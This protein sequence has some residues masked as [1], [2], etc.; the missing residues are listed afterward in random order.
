M[1]L[2]KREPSPRCIDPGDWPERSARRR[3]LI[4][5]PDRSDLWAHAEILREAGY[6]V[7]T[8]TGPTIGR[9]SVSMFQR[10]SLPIEDAEPVRAEHRSLCPLVAGERCRLADGADVVISTTALVD[11]RGILAA[12]SSTGQA[13]LVVEGTKRIL[14]RNSDV[15]GAAT[16]IEQPVTQERLVAAVEEALGAPSEAQQ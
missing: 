5:N 9:E 12:H 15:I 16:V 1:T 2:F 14:A 7:A 13:A 4:E 6:D 3:V 8:C 10:G 11:A